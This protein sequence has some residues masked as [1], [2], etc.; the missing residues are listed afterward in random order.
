MA[1]P[2]NEPFSRNVSLT[3]KSR[4]RDLKKAVLEQLGMQEMCNLRCFFYESHDV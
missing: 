2:N 1:P 3:L 4:L